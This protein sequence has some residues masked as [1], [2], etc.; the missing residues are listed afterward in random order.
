MKL[1]ADTLWLALG[2]VGSCEILLRLPFAGR[3]E[4]LKQCIKSVLVWLPSSRVSDHWKGLA[5]RLYAAE[6]MISTVA[7]LVFLM[8]AL[9]PL[10]LALWIASGSLD[11]LRAFILRLE[12][13]FGLTIFSI[14]YLFAR[15]WVRARG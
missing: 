1:G 7:L 3:I 4:R 12:I 14:G 11:A 2:A 8:A 13:F 10:L 9:F 5:A 6:I 15:A